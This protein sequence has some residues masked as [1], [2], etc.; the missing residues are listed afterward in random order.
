MLLQLSFSEQTI[1]KKNIQTN[2]PSR[3]TVSFHEHNR[4][5]QETHC[6]KSMQKTVT[7][8]WDN[9]SGWRKISSNGKLCPT[10]KW[11]TSEA[12]IRP[13][14]CPI[15][16]VSGGVDSR[17]FFSGN[18]YLCVPLLLAKRSVACCSVCGYREEEDKKRAPR[19]W[20]TFHYFSGTIQ[21][22]FGKSG[23]VGRVAWCAL[24]K[25]SWKYSKSVNS[26]QL[27]GFGKSYHMLR[28]ESTHTD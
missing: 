6:K 28:L 1:E 27:R 10:L 12:D 7:H 15:G 26:T 17:P 24:K 5:G 14:W 25:G 2:L 20:I 8:L 18:L 22:A 13:R 4:I 23:H 9:E 3:R 19:N 21:I 11:D 16:Q